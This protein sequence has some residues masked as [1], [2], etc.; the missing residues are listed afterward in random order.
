MAKLITC[1][2]CGRKVSDQASSCP[3]CGTKYVRKQKCVIC[4]KQ[5]KASS[6]VNLSDRGVIGQSGDYFLSRLPTN[7]RL[8]PMTGFAHSDC[9][10]KVHPIYR[11]HASS[12][13]ITKACP[14]CRTQLQKSLLVLMEKGDYQEPTRCGGCGEDVYI[15][16][17][18]GSHRPCCYCGILLNTTDRGQ[19]V[20][21]S[22]GIN[23]NRADDYAHLFCYQQSS[24]RQRNPI[25]PNLL[26]LGLTALV[27]VLLLQ[28]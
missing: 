19:S 10:G 25:W 5:A 26:L 14:T 11:S 16:L 17:I 12:T 1:A 28:P 27:I 15:N 23:P 9:L 8:K 13:R 18:D 6:M 20:P 4:R 21:M 2:E 7:Q 3:H 24:D 22:A